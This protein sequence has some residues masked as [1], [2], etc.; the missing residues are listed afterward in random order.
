MLFHEEFEGVADALRL[1]GVDIRLFGKP[2]S[3]ARRRM[4][5][6]LATAEN[7]DAARDIAKQAAARVKP[8]KNLL[9]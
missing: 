6:A 4:G 9:A 8:V 7:T 2:E 5:V 1:P 3:F